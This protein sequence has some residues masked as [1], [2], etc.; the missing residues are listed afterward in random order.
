MNI[1]KVVFSGSKYLECESVVISLKTTDEVENYTL[2]LKPVNGSIESVEFLGIA[3]SDK[4]SII[5][6][7]FNTSGGNV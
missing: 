2:P 6:A 1:Y 5:Q 7:S 4:R 3:D